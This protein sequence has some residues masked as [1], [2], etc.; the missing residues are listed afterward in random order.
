LLARVGCCGF[1]VPVAVAAVLGLQMHVFWPKT[2]AF[3]SW[4]P[5]LALAAIVEVA[6]RRWRPLGIGAGLLVAAV[7]LPSTVHSLQVPQLGHAPTWSA[8]VSALERL[9]RPGDTI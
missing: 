6:V 2:L 8:E 9:V 7:V 1:A 4:G 5:M 3:A